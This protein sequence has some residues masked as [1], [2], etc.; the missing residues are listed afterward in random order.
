MA[1]D[2]TPSATKRGSTFTNTT[3]TTVYIN[4]RFKVGFATIGN[5][6]TNADTT[7]VNLWEKFGIKTLLGIEA[8]NHNTEDSVIALESDTA[9][10]VTAVDG[11]TLTITVNGTAGAS[12]RVYA[13]YGI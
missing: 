13:L 1:T 10:S 7:T 8:W 9:D 11:Q 12:K 3:D 2:V 5:T 6:T 4:P